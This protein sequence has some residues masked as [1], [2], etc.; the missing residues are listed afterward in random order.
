LHHAAALHVQ[1]YN[2]T[3]QMQQHLR[4]TASSVFTRQLQNTRLSELDVPLQF[5]KIIL[6]TSVGIMDHE[7]ARRKK[8]GGKVGCQQPS[9][10]LSLVSSSCW[11]YCSLCNMLHG[12]SDRALLIAALVLLCAK[13][14]VV[15]ARANPCVFV[16]LCLCSAVDLVLICCRCWDSSTEPW[17]Y[18]CNE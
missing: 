18:L 10:C 17:H 13:Q 15:L 1:P 12:L 9:I 7:E 3:Q 11:D 5:G 16:S 6:T 4:H 14:A 8:M 2:A